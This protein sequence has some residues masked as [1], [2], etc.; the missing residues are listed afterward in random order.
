MKTNLELLVTSCKNNFENEFRYAGFYLCIK[1]RCLLNS[2]KNYTL[3]LGVPDM[4]I[5]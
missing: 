3:E 1:I 5:E 4:K 2:K